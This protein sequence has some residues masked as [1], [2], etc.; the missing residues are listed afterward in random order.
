MCCRQG[1]HITANLL[2]L[3]NRMHVQSYDEVH[4][5]HTKLLAYSQLDIDILTN[6]FIHFMSLKWVIKW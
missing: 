2:D 4:T 3:Y 1:M 5:M 6:T